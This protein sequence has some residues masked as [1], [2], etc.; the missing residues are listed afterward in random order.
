MVCG[1]TG[2]KVWDQAQTMARGKRSQ[3]LHTRHHGWLS[4]AST[5]PVCSSSRVAISFPHAHQHI[6]LCNTYTPARHTHLHGTHKHMR[7]NIHSSTQ[8][9]TPIHTYIYTYI[10][11]YIHTYIH[12]RSK[13]FAHKRKFPSNHS[14]PLS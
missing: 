9:Y 13:P 14:R 3:L 7:T 2:S 6:P 10:D 8:P 11:I 5:N 4:L 1:A 12:T